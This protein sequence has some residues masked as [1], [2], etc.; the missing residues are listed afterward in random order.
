MKQ[1]RANMINGEVN[2]SSKEIEGMV[3]NSSYFEEVRDISD[4]VY[5]D[6]VFAYEVKLDQSIL[7]NAIEHDL[8]EDGYMSDDEEEYTSALLEQ[9]EYFIDAA[10][11]EVKDHIEER[12]HLQNME[13]AYD[14][15]QGSRGVDHIHFVLTLSFGATHHGQLYQLTNSIID[16]NYTRN[17][18]GLH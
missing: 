13:S 15:Y 18:R 3:A 7:E 16:K 14:I 10:I 5:D 17:S 8:E 4:R 1:T 9:A 2:I 11:D 12:Y 6:D